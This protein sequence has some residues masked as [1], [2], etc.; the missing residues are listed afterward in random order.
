MDAKQRLNRPRPPPR[1]CPSAEPS[2]QLEQAES[3]FRPRTRRTGC[4]AA[5]N[6][7]WAIVEHAGSERCQKGVESSVHRPGRLPAHPVP[8]AVDDRLRH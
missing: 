6:I 8:G 2:V 3:R 5:S 4:A 1:P 7:G